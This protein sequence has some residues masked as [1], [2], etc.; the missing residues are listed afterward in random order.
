M[1]DEIHLKAQMDY[2]GGNIFGAAF[3]SIEAA[4]SAFVLMISSI[5]SKF[6]DV[7]ILPVKS[8]SADTLHDIL[9]KVIVGLEERRKHNTKLIC[10]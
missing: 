7:Q 6:K 10:K 3:K 9:K 2:K 8:M 1:V 5:L 4:T